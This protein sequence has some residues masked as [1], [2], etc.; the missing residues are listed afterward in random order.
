MHDALVGDDSISEAIM[1]MTDDELVRAHASLV[2]DICLRVTGNAQDAADVSQEVF[3]AWMQQ[4]QRIRGQVAAWLHTTARQRALDWL[5][6]HHRRANHERR[7]EPCA[8]DSGQPATE[9]DWRSALDISLSQLDVRQRTLVIEHHFLGMSQESLAS[10]WRT[11]QAS[12]SRQLSR[13][14]EL[15]RRGLARQGI[16]DATLGAM[17]I[18]L[19]GLSTKT[20]CPLDLLSPLLASTHV[21]GPGS[22]VAAD[23]TVRWWMSWPAIAAAAG[24]LA[25]ALVAIPWRQPAVHDIARA[26]LGED[27]PPAPPPPVPRR[28]DFFSTAVECDYQSDSV[29]DVLKD[30]HG[31]TGLWYAMPDNVG[32]STFMSRIGRDV[33]LSDVL[34]QAAHDARL[35]LEERELEGRSVA[36]FRATADAGAL[37]SALAHGLS[38]DPQLRRGA[39]MELAGMSCAPA[40]A[41]LAR[42]ATDPELAVRAIA[43]REIGMHGMMLTGL[44]SIG[45]L[46]FIG[47][48]ARA[49]LDGALSRE[50]HRWS[51]DAERDVL[52]IL[53][54]LGDGAL[55]HEILSD[56]QDENRVIAVEGLAAGPH[57]DWTTLAGLMSERTMVER[58]AMAAA[59]D[60]S[61]LRDPCA[62]AALCRAL[63]QASNPRS[64]IAYAIAEAPDPACLPALLPLL[65]DADTNL[66]EAAGSALAL[67]HDQR[68]FQAIRSHPNPCS[69]SILQSAHAMPMDPADQGDTRAIAI[70]LGRGPAACARLIAWADD[71]RAGRPSAEGHVD[72]DT[73]LREIS[74]TRTQAAEDY[75]LRLLR[76]AKPMRDRNDIGDTFSIICAIT[77]LPATA[78]LAHQLAVLAPQLNAPERDILVTSEFPDP[79]WLETLHVMRQL[80]TSYAPI[81]LG[82]LRMP[83]ATAELLSMAAT[84]SDE[85]VW[86]CEG[87]GYDA[88]PGA[89]QRLLG[90]LQ[91]PDLAVRSA[92]LAALAQARDPTTLAAVEQAFAAAW[93]TANPPGYDDSAT[94]YMRAPVELT[95]VRISPSRALLNNAAV[96]LA[97][98]EGP[99]ALPKLIAAW[100]RSGECRAG[101][102]ADRANLPDPYSRPG[103]CP[104]GVRDANP[105]LTELMRIVPYVQDAACRQ[106]LLN[107]SKRSFGAPQHADG[108]AAPHEF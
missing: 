83:L 24:A 73:L 44:P 8:A 82:R 68:A 92:A 65:A 93:S 22:L 27:R 54:T 103:Y 28:H 23:P 48:D 53:N 88:S 31:Q 37:T 59:Q 26:A 102:R 46:A 49:A 17:P 55:A 6:R 20:P 66:A 90:F 38:V 32:R 74:S 86:L 81:A 77:G 4:R 104:P 39:V 25:V 10:R 29:D 106:A 62:E 101:V 87:L 78:T 43:R 36:V 99:D 96:A 2:F 58:V 85:K 21:A 60:L 63:G 7:A 15:L 84:S 50:P 67:M 33:P 89:A 105:R 5:R 80:G 30:L 98:L 72:M 47:T 97:E 64:T 12:I 76:E 91:D 100:A 34:E 1:P 56:G 45:Y 71:L 3:V 40:V 13:A 95:T 94:V 51:R 16:T 57:P 11:S 61:A 52:Q 9:A 41:A 75:L 79:C 42:L 19:G 69:E 35:T 70:A 18:M 108:R 14:L 107:W